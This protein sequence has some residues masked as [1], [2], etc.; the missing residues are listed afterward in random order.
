[1]GSGNTTHNAT[2]G[3]PKVIIY[4]VGCARSCW[5]SPGARGWA[6]VRV[7]S[8]IGECPGA[9]FPP[10]NSALG[11]RLSTVTTFLERAFQELSSGTPYDPLRPRDGGSAQ[12]GT[13]EP[14]VR[15]L[16]VSGLAR[17]AVARGLLR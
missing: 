7:D 16:G 12:G 10:D 2:R 6:A 9:P 4:L 14:I 17:G 11:D 15:D 3:H 8:S 13:G 1:M 5:S